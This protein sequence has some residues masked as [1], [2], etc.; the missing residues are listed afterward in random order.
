MNI[1]KYIG[2]PFVRGGRTLHKDRGLDCYGLAKLFYENEYNIILPEYEGIDTKQD[3]FAYCSES[4][5]TLS[6]YKDFIQVD[7]PELGDLLLFNVMGLPVHIGIYVDR[8]LM[9][10]TF[11]KSNSAIENYTRLKW[12]NKLYG[13]YRH[14]KQMV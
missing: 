6:T 8:G 10:H 2:L 3:D 1:E 14:K 12:K 5:M 7:N 4:I 9:L 11:D 13:V